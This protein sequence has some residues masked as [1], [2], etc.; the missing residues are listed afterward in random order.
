MRANNGPDRSNDACNHVSTNRIVNGDKYAVACS[1]AGRAVRA[2]RL[3]SVRPGA[4]RH[5]QNSSGHGRPSAPSLKLFVKPQYTNRPVFNFV[6]FKLLWPDIPERR[7]Y[8][9]HRNDR[10]SASDIG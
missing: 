6:L 3:R 5:D 2:D 8:S 10:L 9:T 4:Y 7:K 1:P